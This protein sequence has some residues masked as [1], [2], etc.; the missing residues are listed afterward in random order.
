MFI[1]SRKESD[2]M[3]RVLFCFLA[4]A[5]IAVVPSAVAPGQTAASV[6]WN[7]VAPDSAKP[8]AIVGNL[9]ATPLTGTNFEIRDYTGGNAGPLGTFM[10]WWPGSGVLWGP[11][12]E[13]VATRYI[14]FS[15]AP[16]AG[17]SFTVDSL[18]FLSAGGGTGSMRLNVYYS[19]DPAFGTRTIVDTT[20]H[21][22]HATNTGYA[23]YAYFVGTTVNDAEQFCVRFN[24][25]Y[26]GAASSS[27]YVYTQ[28]V[29]IKGTVLTGIDDEPIGS[30]PAEFALY[31]NYPN[32]FNPSTTI[33]YALPFAS[34][35]VLDVYDL[36]GRKVA[37]L[38][39]ERMPAGTHSVR[40]DA[41][42]LGSGMYIYRL[43]AGDHA[44]SKRMTVVK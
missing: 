31:Q 10:R 13:E 22:P 3:A 28:L 29:V 14:Q 25:Y 26:T 44:V 30:M 18:T 33:E 38:V 2:M 20:I 23:R 32:P 8:S 17:S 36:L 37:S 19:K 27:K 1:Q 5:L 6:T 15:A 39:N 21:L 40:L 24:P 42:G 35:V 7:C 34:H 12:T 16:T 11:E 9:T 43:M 4:L 41:S